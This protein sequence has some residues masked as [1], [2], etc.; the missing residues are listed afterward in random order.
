MNRVEIK[1]EAKKI[2]SNNFLNYW[3]AMLLVMLISMAASIAV[4][5]I[6]GNDT[7]SGGIVSTLVELAIIPLSIG[8]IKY[9]LDMVRGKDFSIN[10]LFD[11]YKNI[12]PIVAAS[13][14]AS[15]IVVIGS[16]LLIIPGIIAALAL[17]MIAPIFAD[18]E[19]D[20]IE[21]L[22]KSNEM[23]KGYK[24]DY[25]VFILSFLGW[26]LLGCVTCGLAFIW[27]IPYI[28]V[29]EMIYYDKLKN[30]EVVTLE[31]PIEKELERVEE[32]KEEKPAKKTTTKKTTAKKNTSKKTT[33]KKTTAKKSTKTK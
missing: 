32:K 19:E 3:K 28:T 23:M 24:W 5:L 1:E 7:V 21:A 2:L 27:V 6:F 29:S 12:L 17:T 13:I 18:G 26:I 14:L 9:V 4:D 11:Y 20:P 31:T 8:Y 15:V 33:A 22:K 10:N 25:F 16:F 30:H